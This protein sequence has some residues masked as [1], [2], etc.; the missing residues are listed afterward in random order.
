MFNN[1][2]KRRDDNS[3]NDDDYSQDDLEVSNELLNEKNDDDYYYYYYYDENDSKQEPSIPNLE[4]SD[5]STEEK[6]DYY[7]TNEET[8]VSPF[9][10]KEPTEEA[11]SEE[12]SIDF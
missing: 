4:S 8:Y 10:S 1:W 9:A 6:L 11:N 5:K 12:S 7:D 3:S 2:L